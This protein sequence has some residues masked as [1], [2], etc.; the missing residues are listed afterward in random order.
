M[1]QIRSTFTFAAA[2]LLG[3]A[4]GTAIVAGSGNVDLSPTFVAM[5]AIVEAKYMAVVVAV[6]AAISW[7]YFL[8]RAQS[9]EVPWT[10]FCDGTI[11][12]ICSSVLPSLYRPSTLT[13][14]AT[15]LVTALIVLATADL[16]ATR[17]VS[18]SRDDA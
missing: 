5:L 7:P 8:L 4:I 3:T 14:V 17:V 16:A 1:S 13:L 18:I 10:R 2:A 6:G 15:L 9:R 12:G 11:Y